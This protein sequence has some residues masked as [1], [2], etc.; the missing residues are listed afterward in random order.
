MNL[1]QE[2]QLF[3]LKNK[4]N[5]TRMLKT[6]KYKYLYDYICENTPK[7]IMSEKYPLKMKI[8]WI[9]NDLKD[10]PKCGNPKC[11]NKLHY[12]EYS[13]INGCK[14]SCSSKCAREIALL[15][16]IKTCN[17]RYGT[18]NGGGIPSSL[19][20]IKSTN[21][22]KFGTT[23]VFS[24]A[25]GKNK[26][27]NTCLKK[28]GC[29]HYQSSKEFLEKIKKTNRKKYGVD[30][31][32]QC[33]KIMDKTKETCKNKYGV[34]W[35]SNDPK[36]E[37]SHHT[38]YF[39]DNLNFDSLP[40]IAFYIWLKDHKIE[41]FEY[42]PKISFKYICEDKV[43][44]YMPDFR[45][46]DNY[47]EIKGDHFFKDNRMICPF[48]NKNWTVDDKKKIDDLYESK[49]QCMLENNVRILRSKEYNIY[50]RYVKDKYG[51][52]FLNQFKSSSIGT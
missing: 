15:N 39:F 1:K 6:Q 45:V 14:K 11:N 48:K 26:I 29:E 35:F 32:L 21:L 20:K 9:L 4:I 27:K 8:F 7:I 37:S 52:N 17:E 13:L 19:E 30:F 5:A 10:F 2:L 24:S 16:T 44:Y 34:D 22:K 47:I 38:K 23:N 41:N 18:T 40:E 33:K 43:H 50:I 46:G 25:Y 28:Y 49:H 42:K 51:S 31:P 3:C 36:I 12:T